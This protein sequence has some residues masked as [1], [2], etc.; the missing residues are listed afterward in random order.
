MGACCNP[1]LGLFT[2]SKKNN[3]DGYLFFKN[4]LQSIII[5]N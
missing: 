2:N 4:K 1:L 3:L 5:E